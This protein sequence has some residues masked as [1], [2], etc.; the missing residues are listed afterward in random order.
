M[1]FLF[2]LVLLGAL[3]ALYGQTQSL[4]Y[5]VLISANA[6]WR[7]VTPLFRGATLQHSPYGDYFF[8]TINQQRVLFFQGGWGK[9]AAAGSTQYVVDHFHPARLVNL[10]TCGGVEGRIHRFDT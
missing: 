8:T 10:G 7:A 5:A 6:E 1:P 2:R 3:V 9:V 4:P